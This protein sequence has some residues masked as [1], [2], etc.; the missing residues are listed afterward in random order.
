MALY[1]NYNQANKPSYDQWVQYGSW[2]G[3][4]FNSGSR[5]DQGNKDNYDNY[6]RKQDQWKAQ[7]NTERFNNNLELH[8]LVDPNQ[9]WQN[10]QRSAE[11]ERMANIGAALDAINSMF[12]NRSGLY[13]NFENA[14]FDLNRKSLEDSFDKNKLKAKFALARGGL[15]GGSADTSVNSDLVE[16]LNKGIIN[17]RNYATNQANQFREQDNQ[18]RAQLSGLAMTG[19]VSPSQITGG[20]QLNSSPNASYAPGLNDAF[21]G[22]YDNVGG[23]M[24]ALGADPTA[25]GFGDKSIRSGKGSSGM[26]FNT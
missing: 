24:Y 10:Q 11:E 15:T 17:A 5:S 13:N 22:I 16:G 26:V 1:D 12:S 4:P 8:G 2:Q 21:S 6:I 20:V 9:V 23:A 25:P 3:D 18:M 14:T 19:S 7:G